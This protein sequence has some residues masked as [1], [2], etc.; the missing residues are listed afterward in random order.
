[1]AA[2][3]EPD[4]RALEDFIACALLRMGYDTAPARVFKEITELATQT[5]GSAGPLLR[6]PL[7]W[8]RT[9][10]DA[11]GLPEPD[12]TRLLDLAR[13]RARKAVDRTP[14]LELT[15][16][17]WFDSSYPHR[18]RTL[19]N[20]P[21]VLWVRGAVTELSAPAVAI[22][23]SRDATP[24]GLAMAEELAEG[25]AEAG[26]TVVSGLAR[27]IDGAA[28]R[29]A[30]R[31]GGRTVAVLGCGLDTPYPAR[32]LELAAEV[33]RSGA[34][35]GELPPGTPP[36]PQHFPLRNRIISGL[37]RAVVVVE[38]SERSGSLITARMALDQGR[39]VLAVPGNVR[40]GQ[41]RGSH[42]LIKDGARLVERVQDVLEE[43]G[44]RQVRRSGDAVEPGAKP[45]TVQW[46]EA[47]MA[48]GETY[49]AD[50]LASRTGRPVSVLLAEL[51][52]LE[53]AGRVC[54]VPGGWMRPG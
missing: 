39:D 20:P 54:R 24:S 22:V 18:L 12:R 45:L 4:P 15:M 28:H 8:A 38:A 47:R 25:V 26:F 29:G 41:Y 37:S 2:P 44:W 5:G 14:R 21:L 19:A 33:A 7:G 35:V 40:S 36:L 3:S 11:L 10:S 42:A 16:V 17:T 51:G 50:Q 53:V 46:L 6:P 31:A 30:L 1:M 32:N 13:E 9:V 43:L 27:G 23:G 48:V 49:T 52:T 34:L